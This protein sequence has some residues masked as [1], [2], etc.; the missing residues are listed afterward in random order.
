MTMPSVGARRWS[1]ITT[2]M[3]AAWTIGV[4]LATTP[5]SADN[6][7]GADYFPNVP[8]TTQDGTVVR[9][10]DDL[11][12]GKS[13]AVDLIYTTCKY[14]CPLETARLVQ[15]QRVL[16][17]RVGR[18]IFFYSITIDP[19]H[20]T[21]AVLKEYA[22]RYHVGPGWTFLT[23]TAAD[24]ELIS[25]KLGLYSAPNPDNPDGHTPSLLV[26][27]EPGGQWMRNSALDNPMFL[28]RTMSDWLDGWKSNAAKPLPSFAEVPMVDIDIGEY[29]FRN[30]C[31]AC[32]SIGGGDAIG[33]DLKGVTATREHAWLKRFIARPDQVIDEGDPIARRLLDQYKQ[34][35]MPSLSLTEQDA[36]VLIDYIGRAGGDP[37]FA[38]GGSKPMPPMP[39]MPDR[40]PRRSQ[41]EASAAASRDA[42]ARTPALMNTLIE[43]YLRIQQALAEDRIDSVP[44][45]ALALANATVKI[46]SPAATIRVAINPFAQAAD[47]RT[48][49]EAFGALS[50]ALIAYVGESLSDGLAVAYCPMAKKSWLQRGDAIQ[51]PYYGK[52]MADCGRVVRRA[53]D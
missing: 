7:W 15:V 18:D 46:G 5:V 31:V 23:G 51:N 8:L 12:K 33:P 4:V 20:D 47:L 27:N 41:P 9:F 48:A 25:K 3:A 30:H 44:R 32:H 16:G 17:D 13:V 42:A 38:G 19:E 26:G 2:V 14:A 36:A 28:A 34:V 43:P 22:E 29:T 35:R 39:A 10:Y 45:D 52:A 50:D 6:R 40:Q 53:G 1:A 24:I 37:A 49:R 21:P 11:I